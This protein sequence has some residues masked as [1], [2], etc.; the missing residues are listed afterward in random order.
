MRSCPHCGGEVKGRQDKKYCSLSCQ[1]GAYRVRAGRV[2]SGYIDVPTGTV[3]AMAELRVCVDL[4]SR[5]WH[6][7]RAQSPSCPVDLIAMKEGLCKMVEVK[8]GYVRSTGLIHRP[9]CVNPYD[10]LCIV[11]SKGMFYRDPQE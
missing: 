7:F 9:K 11:T 8:T 6:V 10:V 3:G 1:T 4:M 5:G 2:G